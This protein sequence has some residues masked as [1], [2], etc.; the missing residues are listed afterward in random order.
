[1]VVKG[2]R[3]HIPGRKNYVVKTFVTTRNVGIFEGF[4]DQ[5]VRR[6]ES[7]VDIRGR[8]SFRNDHGPG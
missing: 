2:G 6:A 1:M 3:K 8:S 7:R 4:K 5:H